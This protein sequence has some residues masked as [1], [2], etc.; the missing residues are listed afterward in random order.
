MR[1]MSQL[2]DSDWT[3][4]ELSDR[5]A[6][7]LNLFACGATDSIEVGRRVFLSKWTVRHYMKSV[8]KKLGARNTAH[9]VAIAIR[10]DLIAGPSRR[11]VGH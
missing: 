2:A 9:A 6:E 5:E 1:A 10:R 4:T 3:V 11:T 7:I 8:R